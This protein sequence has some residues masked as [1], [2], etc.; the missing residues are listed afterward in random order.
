MNQTSFSR[1]PDAVLG[2]TPEQRNLAIARL[3]DDTFRWVLNEHEGNAV[4]NAYGELTPS[5][6][7]CCTPDEFVAIVRW[8]QLTLNSEN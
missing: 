1:V 2:V 8:Y 5:E 3:L 6:Q 4:R 7:E